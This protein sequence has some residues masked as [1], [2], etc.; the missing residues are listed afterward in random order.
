M[1]LCMTMCVSTILIYVEKDCTSFFEFK[2][3]IYC[4]R[5]KSLFY[6]TI[7]VMLNK[8]HPIF[9]R[10]ILLNSFFYS[11]IFYYKCTYLVIVVKKYFRESSLSQESCHTA[12][13]I[14]L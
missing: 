7:Y 8:D 14:R 3:I 5:V 1:Q 13:N 2:D 9:T 10:N 6:F 12:T 4:R 11:S